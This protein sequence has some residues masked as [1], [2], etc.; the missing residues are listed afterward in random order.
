[1]SDIAWELRNLADAIRGLIDFETIQR[2]RNNIGALIESLEQYTEAV[3][4]LIDLLTPKPGVPKSQEE[5]IAFRK[6]W[7]EEYDRKKAEQPTRD[8]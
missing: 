8:R 4:N 5:K 1:M 7:D 3:T 2:E 6:W